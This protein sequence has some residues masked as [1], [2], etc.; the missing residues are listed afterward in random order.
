MRVLVHNTRTDF[1]AL[2]ERT[3]QIRLGRAYKFM[4]RIYPTICFVLALLYLASLIYSWR[5]LAPLAPIQGLYTGLLLLA[6]T[7]I[8][9]IVF[10][11][12]FSTSKR[13]WHF[14]VPFTLE[15]REDGVHIQQEG[16]PILVPWSKF[17]HVS[18]DGKYLYLLRNSRRGE[19][20]SYIIPARSFSSPDEAD[21][22]SKAVL[23]LWLQ[24]SPS[25]P[26]IAA[27]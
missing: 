15:L 2:S 26:P 19:D 14:G 12:S 27:P 10:F 16:K 9:P 25:R 20:H 1:M 13:K 18:H 5:C 3:I 7:C 6:A 23:D 17:H 22:F 21:T 4:R 24:S 8:W 11:F